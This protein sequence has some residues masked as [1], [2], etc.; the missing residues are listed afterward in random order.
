MFLMYSKSRDGGA[1][2]STAT[3]IVPSSDGRS[4]WGPVL[5]CAAEP[6]ETGAEVQKLALFYAFSRNSTDAFS[7]PGGDLYSIVSY[8]DGETWTEEPRLIMSQEDSAMGAENPLYFVNQ[9]IETDT[10]YLIPYGST[11][12]GYPS[13]SGA[14][15]LLSL[16]KGPRALEE[17][18]WETI[19]RTFEIPYGE[20][21][22]PMSSI[23]EPALAKITQGSEDK[24]CV[25]YFRSATNHLWNTRTS[26]PTCLAGWQE[27]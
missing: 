3:T 25:M 17:G 20:A 24:G 26:D 16:E 21:G 7:N 10:H 18:T 4:A 6:D 9:A 15:S 13:S 27:P 2:W 22:T 11:S 1:S 12:D 23:L 8:D 14:A 19:A 5:T